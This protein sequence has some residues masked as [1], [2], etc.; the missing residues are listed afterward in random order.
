M[1]SGM[2]SNNPGIPPENKRL[3]LM[4]LQAEQQML[5]ARAV[6]RQNS[7]RGQGID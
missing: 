6:V 7:V 4:G 2:I 5:T 1:Q 3:M